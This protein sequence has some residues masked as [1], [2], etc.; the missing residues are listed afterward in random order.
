MI[1]YMKFTAEQEKSQKR[2][3][4]PRV[5][6]FGRLRRIVD[7]HGMPWGDSTPSTTPY[8]HTLT[9]SLY[10]KPHF[11]PTIFKKFGFSKIATIFWQF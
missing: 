11:K 9:R 6:L 7:A 1:A 5:L 3:D 2:G 10:L 8:E 4:H